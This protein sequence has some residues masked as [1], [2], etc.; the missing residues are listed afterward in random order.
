MLWLWVQ[1]QGQFPEL[2]SNRRVEHYDNS[3]KVQN[4]AGE[5]TQ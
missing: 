4:H 2:I 5:A 1:E 3:G